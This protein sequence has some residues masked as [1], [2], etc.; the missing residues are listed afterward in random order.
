MQKNRF[1]AAGIDDS[2]DE[3]LQ[4]KT[5]TQ[6]KKEE[7]KITEKKPVPA[8]KVNAQQ[9]EA[10]GFEVVSKT[11][12]KTQ[13]AEPRRGGRGERGSRGGERGGRGGERGGRGRG[14]RGGRGG[15]RGPR[16]VRT[17]ADGN[18]IREENEIK[19]RPY[20]GKPREEAHPMDRK[21]GTGRGR[22]PIN[23][24][25]GHGKGNVGQSEDVA[26]KKKNEDGTEEAV[27]AEEPK[28]E[29]KEEEPKVII[30]E[31]VIGVSMDDF[32]GTRARV[33][34]KQGRDA[35][36]VKGVKVEGLKDEKVKQSTQQQNQYAKQT[37]AKTSDAEVA[38]LTG[39]GTIVDEEDV[40]GDRR[41]GRGGR[42]TN[43][44]RGGRRQNPKQALKKTEED[45]P[46]L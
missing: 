17:D 4:Q 31:E 27:Q 8:A 46:S 3:V 37:L 33:G 14:E 5:K 11:Q 20:T 32:L 23:K 7:R 13:A 29:K 44:Q 42:D 21:S 28:E 9:M 40:R 16:P 24:K 18:P 1:A 22:R 41:G 2:D 12:E 10:G 19:R 25:D 43:T 39:F 45:F 26:Y 6:I 34:P 35:E 15:E 36:G 30:K 38:K